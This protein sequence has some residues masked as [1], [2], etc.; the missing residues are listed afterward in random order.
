MDDSWHPPIGFLEATKDILEIHNRRL[1]FGEW[2]SIFLRTSRLALCHSWRR[3]TAIVSTMI[4]PTIIGRPTAFLFLFE[5]VMVLAGGPITSY[6]I[7]TKKSELWCVWKMIFVA[8]HTPWQLQAINPVGTS[9]YA[10]RSGANY[11]VWF[12]IWQCDSDRRTSC[13]SVFLLCY[14][15]ALRLTKFFS[16]QSLVRRSDCFRTSRKSKTEKMSLY[17]I[18][19]MTQQKQH[20]RNKLLRI[21]PMMTKSISYL[22]N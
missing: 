19:P 7:M 22:L 8:D 13:W 5:W 2:R 15:V 12:V 21:I 6:L 20:E 9:W 4:E 11:C 14:C 10:R 1:L 18:P 17:L 3:L 16:T